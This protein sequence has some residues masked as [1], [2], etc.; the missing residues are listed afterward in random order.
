M[1]VIDE[2]CLPY[3]FPNL[4]PR[5]RLPLFRSVSTHPHADYKTLRSGYSYLVSAILTPHPERSR[6]LT[7][8]MP[9]EIK[10]N[11][12]GIP[13]IVDF[14]N[15]SIRSKKGEKATKTS[16]SSTKEKSLKPPKVPPKVPSKVPTNFPT[17]PTRCPTCGHLPNHPSDHKS[18]L[19][20]STLKVPEPEKPARHPKPGGL[21]IRFESSPGVATAKLSSRRLAKLRSAIEDAVTN[22]G[23]LKPAVDETGVKDTGG[24]FSLGGDTVKS[25]D[26]MRKDTSK[27]ALFKG[28]YGQV[29]EALKEA[30]LVTIP[31]SENGFENGV[32][33]CFCLASSLPNKHVFYSHE[34]GC[35]LRR[36][37]RQG[38][39]HRWPSAYQI[40]T[41][42][43]SSW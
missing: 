8:A 32:Y 6:S 31:C 29:K 9:S 5:V 10:F 4:K 33:R 40:N 23:M 11:N 21:Y 19:K 20:S 18:D 3:G 28:T 41:V 7:A 37:L 26:T 27:K 39:Q 24:E 34:T 2:P 38:H 12:F 42:G 14:A 22:A 25:R 43:L 13:Y 16:K 15:L 1:C 30:G 17:P 35:S 36:Q